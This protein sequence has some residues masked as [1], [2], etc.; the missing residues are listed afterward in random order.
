MSRVGTY[1]ERLTE[2]YLASRGMIV[3]RAAGSMGPWDLWAVANGGDTWHVQVKY[4]GR[5]R[6]AD[7]VSQ[8]KS[9]FRVELSAACLHAGI[10]SLGEN[11]NLLVV[12]SDGRAWV[13]SVHPRYLGWDFGVEEALQS[14]MTDWYR[15]RVAAVNLERRQRAALARAKAVAGQV[16]S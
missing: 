1:Y 2:H 7:G 4:V 6:Y 3:V 16:A 14:R 15:A 5:G 8:A 11:L 13:W 12:W 9:R 10:T